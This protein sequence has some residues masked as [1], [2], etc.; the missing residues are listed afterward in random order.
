MSEFLKWPGEEMLSSIT[1]EPPE[2]SV[3][4]VSVTVVVFLDEALGAVLFFPELADLCLVVFSLADSA[5]GETR[6][7]RKV[8]RVGG[9][10]LTDL[11]KTQAGQMKSLT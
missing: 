10:S 2:L 5:A 1:T 6:P 4:G 8:A 7:C 3:L 9:R 11:R